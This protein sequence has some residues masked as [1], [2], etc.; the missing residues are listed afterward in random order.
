MQ[1]KLFF[2]ILLLLVLPLFLYSENIKEESVSLTKNNLTKNQKS[3]EKQI[4]EQNKLLEEVVKNINNEKYLNLTID[5]KTY[6]KEIS[7]LTN[8]INI[9]KIQKNDLA[10]VRDEL[11]REYLKQK[12]DFEL[13]LKNISL[14]KLEYKD[15][16]YFENL[17]KSNLKS[18]EKITS[19]CLIKMF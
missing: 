1:S 16:K 4:E 19:S 3:I 5:K 2:K 9:N 10:V 11:K 6:K 15:K 8:K 14:A 12:Y 18:L 17:I 13:T 7:L